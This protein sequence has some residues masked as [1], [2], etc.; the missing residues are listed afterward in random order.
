MIEYWKARRY[1]YKLNTTLYRDIVHQAYVKYFER[2]GLDLFQ[3]PN[4]KIMRVVRNSYYELLREYSYKRG[5]K[6]SYTRYYYEFIEHGDNYAV[7]K[8]TPEDILIGNQLEER[9]ADV[10]EDFKYPVVARDVIDLARQGYSPKEISTSLNLAK[11]S[12]NR[13]IAKTCDKL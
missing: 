3:Q 9:L 8:T 10:I 1:A 7:T 5:S 2:T 6:N 11:S 12:V 13:Y 4:R